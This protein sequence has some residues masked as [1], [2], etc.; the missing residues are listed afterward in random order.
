MDIHYISK[1]EL[2]I[3]HFTAKQGGSMPT[4]H[5]LERMSV[6]GIKPA[7]PGD[8]HNTGRRRQKKKDAFE[9]NSQRCIHE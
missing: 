7:K 3:N 6:A 8:P 9:N 4:I 1:P 5:G 2:C